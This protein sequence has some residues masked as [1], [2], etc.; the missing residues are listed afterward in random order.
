MVMECVPGFETESDYL[1]MEVELMNAFK[2]GD[3]EKI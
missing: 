2:C 1:R 3:I